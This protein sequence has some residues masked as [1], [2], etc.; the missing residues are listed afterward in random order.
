MPQIQLWISSKSLRL[1]LLNQEREMAR[2]LNRSLLAEDKELNPLN[3]S[4]IAQD[5]EM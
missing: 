2:S 1:S 4:L 3:R 5:R